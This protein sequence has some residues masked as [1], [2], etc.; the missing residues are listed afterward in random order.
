[1]SSRESDEPSARDM[2][3]RGSAWFNEGKRTL[4][5]KATEFGE[6]GDLWKSLERESDKM[7]STLRRESPE[8][9]KAWRGQIE[10]TVDW[11]YSMDPEDPSTFWG[12]PVIE[13][14]VFTGTATSG[15]PILSTSYPLIRPDQWTELQAG[16]AGFSERRRDQQL[17]LIHI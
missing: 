4:V 17:S 11:L 13:A 6:I 14:A 3:G 1:M 5:E 7:E 12:K 15:S 8:A 9:H 16:F 10:G 2:L